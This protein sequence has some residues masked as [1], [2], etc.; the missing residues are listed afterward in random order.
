MSSAFFI[1]HFLAGLR[2]VGFDA[3]GFCA[4]GFV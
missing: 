4:R 2:V 1:A 3:R